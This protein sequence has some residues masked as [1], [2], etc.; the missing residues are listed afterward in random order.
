VFANQRLVAIHAAQGGTRT[1]T[2]PIPCREV[3]ELYTQRVIP[4]QQQ[5]FE[6]TFAEPDTA[7]FELSPIVAPHSVAPHSVR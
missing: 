2:L 4:V 6:Y 1:I 3:K 5:R 7:L